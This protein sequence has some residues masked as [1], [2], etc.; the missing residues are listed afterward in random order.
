VDK[1]IKS[2]QKDNAHDKKFSTIFNLQISG[3]PWIAE[4]DRISERV[5]AFE[6]QRS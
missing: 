2:A 6:T 4:V 3:M 5:T 1:S